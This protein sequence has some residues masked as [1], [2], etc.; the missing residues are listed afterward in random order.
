M[1]NKKKILIVDDSKV[2]L[3]VMKKYL[4]GKG[5]DV[6]TTNSAIDGAMITKEQDISLVITDINMPEVSGL[7]FLLWIKKHSPNI[8]VIVMTAFGSQETKNF[9][10]SHGGISYFEKSNDYSSLENTI[11]Q[12]FKEKNVEGNIKEIT[13][14]DFVQL[15]VISGKNKCV[16][17]KNRTENKDGQIYFKDGKIVHAKYDNMIGEEALYHI[18][19]TNN[20]EFSDTGWSE[21]ETISINIPFEYLIMNIAQRIDE[22]KNQT[23]QEDTPEIKSKDILIVDDESTTLKLIEAY[24]SS[25]NFSVTIT[26]SS[27]KAI[28][29]MKNKNFGV[30]LSDINMPQIDGFQLMSWVK[31]N[32]AHTKFMLMTGQIDDEHEIFKSNSDVN[33]LEKPINLSQLE[34]HINSILNNNY[35]SGNIQDINLFDFIQVISMSRKNKVINIEDPFMNRKGKIFLKE[36]NIIHSDFEN[37]SGE[38]AF[39]EIAK[40]KG[41]IFSDEEWQEP[42]NKTIN[43][44]LSSLLIK[45][46]N[47]IATQ[48]KPSS[49]SSTN[50]I[51]ADLTYLEKILEEREQLKNLNI[52]NNIINEDGVFAGIVIGQSKKDEITEKLNKY[53]V[54]YNMMKSS[55]TNLI[56]DDVGISINLNEQG[57]VEEMSFNNIFKGT[58]KKGLKI[59]DTIDKAV[60]IYGDPEFMNQN[61]A[62]WSKISIL[63]DL[64]S[65]VNTITIGAI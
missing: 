26:E 64:D 11:K 1:E 7:D 8:R 56:Y 10:I 54:Y 27:L 23:V 34:G 18:M 61:C 19:N 29:M 63:T 38:E 40:V 46:F 49:D 3:I 21:P 15:I 20:G 39:L 52:N 48:D 31:E 55:D 53:N 5:Y 65:K 35:F 9:V 37:L 59:G 16:K 13:L 22:N 51:S 62:V 41:M 50:K 58:T 36:G 14:F 12:L 42:E 33:C 28:Q 4:E 47:K 32:A 60:E 44:P 2:I 6:I 17:I 25:K 45:T 24:L 30:V 43:V 57:T